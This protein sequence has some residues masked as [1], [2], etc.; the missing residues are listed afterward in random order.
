[1]V[2]L[3][4]IKVVRIQDDGSLRWARDNGGVDI[5]DS[6]DTTWKLIIPGVLTPMLRN[7]VTSNGTNKE[8]G[9]S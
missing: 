6:M 3:E 1:M 2:N 8:V 9:R 7:M 5:K 4:L